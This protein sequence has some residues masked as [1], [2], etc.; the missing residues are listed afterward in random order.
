MSNSTGSYAPAS[1]KIGKSFYDQEKMNDICRFK[2]CPDYE[3]C[4][5]SKTTEPPTENLGDEKIE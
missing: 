2:D 5:A 1:Q 3:T 4:W